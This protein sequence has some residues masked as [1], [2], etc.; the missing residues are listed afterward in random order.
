VIAGS[1]PAQ[2]ILV[3]FVV[4]MFL[5]M[6]GCPRSSGPAPW[7][8]QRL[9]VTLVVFLL[10]GMM[11]G[12]GI[13]CRRIRWTVSRTR[14]PATAPVW[15]ELVRKGPHGRKQG[16][17]Q[18]VAERCKHIRSR[19]LLDLIGGTLRGLA[20]VLFAHVARDPDDGV[21]ALRAAGIPNKFRLRWAGKRLNI[22]LLNIADEVQRYLTIKTLISLAT[23]L[24]LGLWF[25]C[26]GWIS[27]GSGAWWR[28]C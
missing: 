18:L 27:R 21:Y 7:T 15:N 6:L 28:F 20:G 1:R 13:D 22:A 11:T 5:A 8:A 4:A 10:L 16:S 12:A 23:G 14:C 3:P 26:A 19:Q 9:A 25:I 17:G 24:L 2:A